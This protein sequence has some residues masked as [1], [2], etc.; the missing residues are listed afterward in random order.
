MDGDLRAAWKRPTARCGKRGVRQAFNRVLKKGARASHCIFRSHFACSA[1]RQC[2]FSTGCK[3]TRRPALKYRD[4]NGENRKRSPAGSVL[5]VLGAMLTL[6][7][8]Y[9]LSMGP[10]LWLATHGYLSDGM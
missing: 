2:C 5:V 7:I 9:A 6:A 1:G 4:M 8:V 3:G 10:M